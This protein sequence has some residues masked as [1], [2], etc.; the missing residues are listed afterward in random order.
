MGVSQSTLSF[1]PGDQIPANSVNQN[2]TVDDNFTEN[3]TDEEALLALV[4]RGNVNVLKNFICTQSYLSLKITNNKGENILL[5]AARSGS[6]ETF[7]YIWETLPVDIDMLRQV[8]KNGEGILLLAARSGS[9]ETFKYI[10]ET[11]PV[12][13]DMLRQVSKNEEGVL[14]LAAKN[15]S[16]E[17]VKYIVNNCGIGLSIEQ[18]NKEGKNAAELA[19]ENG[20]KDV[21][22]Y[23]A[24]ECHLS[25][26]L[27]EYAGPSFG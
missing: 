10:W 23:L 19:L 9:I 2:S 12:D 4:R 18:K 15:G 21:A 26:D 11:L 1:F 25:V 20:H 16:V 3:M 6:V 24:K 22:E 27:D 5:L 14:L 8:S 13:I 7:R 17:L